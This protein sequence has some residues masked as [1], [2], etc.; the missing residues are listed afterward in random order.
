MNNGRRGSES[1]SI[2]LD[3][4][5][6]TLSGGRYMLTQPKGRP[7]FVQ[8]TQYQEELCLQGIPEMLLHLSK[9]G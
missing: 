9:H 4:K 8:D 3:K 5:T 6:A 2:T 7:I 1:E